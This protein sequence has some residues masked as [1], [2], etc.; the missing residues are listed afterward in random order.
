MPARTN[1]SAR[2]GAVDTLTLPLNRRRRVRWAFFLFGLA[3]VLPVLI[4]LAVLT[5]TGTLQLVYLSAPGFLAVLTVPVCIAWFARPGRLPKAD[6][7]LDRSGI[8]L[9]ADGRLLRRDVVLTWERVQ[10]LSIVARTLTID[11]VAWTDLAGDDAAEHKR[12]AKREGKRRGD[13]ALTYGLAK[14]LPAKAQ[15]RDIVTD[16]SGGRV[17]LQ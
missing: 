12:W 6:P 13:R 17:K 4:L 11:P 5:M 14:G 7:V 2:S 9:S 10:A 8:R 16:L 1:P 15:L 3:L